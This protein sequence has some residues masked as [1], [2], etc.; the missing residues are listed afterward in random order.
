MPTSLCVSLEREPE[1]CLKAVLLFLDCSSL[2]F[3]SPPFSDQQLSENPPWNSGKA[4][5]AEGG[6]FPENKRCGIQ[7]GFFAQEPHRALLS[8]TTPRPTVDRL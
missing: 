3:A 7:K 4:V 2:L 6:L 8:Y 1:S 5:E